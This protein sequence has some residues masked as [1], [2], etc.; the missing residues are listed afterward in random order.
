MNRFRDRLRNFFEGRYGVDQLN[1]MI[2]CVAAV[3]LV[4]ASFTGAGI[5]SL[6][7]AGLILYSYFRLMSRNIGARSAENEKVLGFFRGIGSAFRSGKRQAKDPDHRYFRC[8]N[9]HQ[10]VRV[11]KGKGNIQIRC[12]K[13]GAEFIRRT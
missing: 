3:L 7:S 9:C 2:L 1:L 8:P 13:C 12:P 5:L 6:I 4:A 10:T 11:P